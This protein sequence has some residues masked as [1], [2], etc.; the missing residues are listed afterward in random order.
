[1]LHGPPQHAW[2]GCCDPPKVGGARTRVAAAPPPPPL[3]LLPPPA[4]TGCR[5]EGR[6]PPA[7]RPRSRAQG[8][9]FVVPEQWRR[10][11]R[12]H[13]PVTPLGLRLRRGRCQRPPAASRCRGRI[14][15]GARRHS[16]GSGGRVRGWSLAKEDR[17]RRRQRPAR[18]LR[19]STRF[20]PLRRTRLGPAVARQRSTSADPDACF[21]LLAPVRNFPCASSHSTPPPRFRA[22]DPPRLPRRARPPPAPTDCGGTGTAASRQRCRRRVE[23]RDKQLREKER[24]CRLLDRLHDSTFALRP[25]APSAPRPAWPTALLVPAASPRQLE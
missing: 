24:G 19:P 22:S 23:E 20:R 21:L 12:V 1:V 7:P 2:G 14:L 11:S 4:A 25:P 10:L 3:R 9:T 16:Q 17:W 6:S 8:C 18:P 13:R 15:V 5:H